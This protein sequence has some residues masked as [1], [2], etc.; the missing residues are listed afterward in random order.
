[1]ERKP[2]VQDIPGTVVTFKMVPI[3]DGTH[4]TKPIKN[5][6]ISETEVTWDA[7]DIWAFKLDMTTE[8]IVKGVDA[9]SRPTKPYGAPD[10]GYGHNGFAA[11][12]MSYYAAETYCKWLSAK[13]G[14]KYRLPLE[15]EWEYAARAGATEN[16]T[17][18][19]EIAWFWENADDAAQRC[20]TK[21]PNA[22]GLYDMLGNVSEWVQGSNGKPVTCGGSFTHKAKDIRFDYRQTQQPKW[23]ERDPQNP[24]SKWWMP[25]GH[26]VGFRVVC[27]GE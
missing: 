10:R 16:P 19:E 24:K 21:K 7:F 25:D 18:L 5:L 20:A 22:W 26:F 1:M 15:H 11:I 6:Y 4:Q 23:M 9:Q 17:N 8:Q 27:E 12:S 13:T 2:F 3:P 14:K